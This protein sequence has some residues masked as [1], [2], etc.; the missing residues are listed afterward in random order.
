MQTM[1]ARA[2]TALALG[3]VVLAVAVGALLFRSGSRPADPVVPQV[4]ADSPLE[5][6]PVAEADFEPSEPSYSLMP[7]AEWSPAEEQTVPVM[8]D[9]L[10]DFHVVR[11]GETLSEISRHY[12]GSHIYAG[13]IERLNQLANPNHLLVGQRLQLPAPESIP[14]FGR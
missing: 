11:S 2:R 1:P 14:A 4:E 7:E 3:A 8:S 12:Y 10:P 6:A 5:R 9:D 13:D